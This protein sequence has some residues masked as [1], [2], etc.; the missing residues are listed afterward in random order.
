MT[1]TIKNTSAHRPVIYTEINNC[2]DCYKCIRRC[3]VKAIKIEDNRASIIEDQCIYCG[4]CTLVCPS[5]AKKARNDLSLVRHLFKNDKPVILSLAPSWVSVFNNYS[6][7]KF[8]RLLRN[9]GFTHVSETALGAEILSESIAEYIEHSDKKLH[10]STCCPVIVQLIRKYYPHLTDSLTPFKSPM[11]VHASWLRSIYGED[12]S[13]VFAGPCIAKKT[14]LESP[15]NNVE[16]SITFTEL[17]ELILENNYY[18]QKGEEDRS[19]SFEPL[20][21]LKGSI[22]PLD[23]GMLD[24]IKTKKDTGTK[25]LSF[26]G[27]STVKDILEQPPS[28][29]CEPLFLELMACEGGCINGP[30]MPHNRSIALRKLSILNSDSFDNSNHHDFKEIELNTQFDY[31]SENKKTAYGE[32]EIKHS[33]SLIG[34]LS[35]KDELNCSGCGYESC[36][37][38][39]QAM[40]EGKA[41]KYM[42]VSYMKRVAQ[43]KATVLLQKMPYGVVIVDESLHIVESNEAFAL[44]AGNDTELAFKARPGMQGA[45][46]G[47]IIPFSRV[48]KNLI[49]SGNE[50]LDKDIYHDNQIWHVSA[51]TIQKYKLVCGIIRHPE[52]YEIHHGELIEQLTSVIRENM[53]T[54]QKAAALLGENAAR[55]ETHINQIIDPLVKKEL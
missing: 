40:L 53:V 31:V 27:L 21:A 25:F 55:I 36:R 7:E 29:D 47:K 9:I 28:E 3:V 38:F 17:E 6:E 22:F 54:A 4:T 32:E 43:N 19:F 2:Q 13:V 50:R 1:E 24:N 10:I 52:D 49:D 35:E 48:F 39:A 37:H 23:G 33:L 30:G 20:K 8:V 16:V 26:S 11:Q 15:D 44:L 45:S 51:F 14:E 41:E 46:L 5:E 42:C 34:K 12:Y 18:P